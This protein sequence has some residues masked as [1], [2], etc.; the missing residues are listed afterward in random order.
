[1]EIDARL[2]LTLAGMGASI[3]SAFVIVKTR[4]GAVID[5]LRDVEQ[6]LRAL[7]NRIDALD[8]ACNSSAKSIG[9]F[10]D[11]FNPAE[12]D[13]HSRELERHKMEIMHLRES[14]RDL[15]K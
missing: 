9:N 7:D 13:K 12:R 6:R 1:M 11:M 2:L 15:R 4:L 3:V 14:V 5:Q 8:V 10:R